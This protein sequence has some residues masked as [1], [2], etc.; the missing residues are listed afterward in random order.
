MNV[1]QKSF[2][3]D[4]NSGIHPEILQAIQSANQG[5][6]VAYG[7]DPY[8]QSAI[9]KIKDCFGE[10]IDVYFVFSGTGA[11]VLG[12]KQITHSYN[13]IICPETGHIHNDEC[14]APEKWTGCKLLTVPTGDGKIT[15]EGIARHL[16]GIG[17]EHHSQPR[18]VSISQ[19]TEM[20]TVYTPYEIQAIADFVHQ[21]GLWLHMD[22]A[23]LANA[24]ASLE[25]SLRQL[26]ADADVDVL[27]FGGTKNGMLMGECVIFLKRD[28]G[29][30][31][32]YVRKQ[33]TQLMSKMRFVGAQ[34]E[35]YL[36]NDLW[37][38]CAQHANQMAQR[39]A[40]EIRK[41]P[42][43]AITQK[44]ETNAVFAIVPRESI[45]ILQK[46]FFFYV[47]NEKTSEVRWM[48]SFDTTE[49]DVVQFTQFIQKTLQS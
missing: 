9:Q 3:S 17:F 31:F 43:I 20:G 8:T 44:V 22:G 48:T 34:Y 41:I 30:D 45:P 7:D 6:V 27:S 40:E 25:L 19:A 29:R 35:A 33:G 12:L 5:H 21:N 28:L 1:P 18:V 11:N 16:H 32:K 42:Q 10:E 4:N 26:T 23:R 36:S 49:D 13:S 24:A 2:A 39:L 46:E 37:L 38:R 15:V 47:W 14:G